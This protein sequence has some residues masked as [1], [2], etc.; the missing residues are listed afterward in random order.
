MVKKN[1]I[2]AALIAL[3][4]ATAVFGQETG[5]TKYGRI[6]QMIEAAQ[7]AGG[8]F[9]DLSGSGGA[10]G[11]PD[12]SEST[13]LSAVNFPTSVEVKYLGETRRIGKERK[14]AV[15][16]WLREYARKPDAKMFYTNEFLVEEDGVK[17]WIM[18]HENT[19]VARLSGYS[20]INDE[21][22]LRLKIPGFYKKG[23]T[24]DYFLLADGVE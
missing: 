20:R 18:A 1:L 12:N 23:K 16:K 4:L 3:C 14:K 17:Y 22:S 8:V 11:M 7:K 10:A 5:E 19:V 6:S 24:I 15:D 9:S 13:F 2:I 21:V